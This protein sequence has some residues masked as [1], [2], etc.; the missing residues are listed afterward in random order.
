LSPTYPKK[1]I[2]DYMNNI[3]RPEI[4]IVYHGNTIN[5][6]HLYKILKRMAGEE[7]T[8]INNIEKQF[9]DDLRTRF[10]AADDQGFGHDFLE[11]LDWHHHNQLNTI[12]NKNL[13]LIKNIFLKYEKN[14]LPFDRRAAARKLPARAAGYHCNSKKN[15]KRVYGL[16][17]AHDV[18]KLSKI[19]KYNQKIMMLLNDL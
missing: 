19:K 5:F 7:L 15:I 4:A 2:N 13:F 10:L 16:G 14:N 6:D 3:T 8:N 18:S 9:Y 11:T 17:H 12:F 1:N